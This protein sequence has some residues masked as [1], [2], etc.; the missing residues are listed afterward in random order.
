MFAA[1][2]HSN[3]RSK[4]VVPS[5]YLD[6]PIALVDVLANKGRLD[7]ERLMVAAVL[8][9][10][11]E[12]THVGGMVHDLAS[13]AQFHESARYAALTVMPLNPR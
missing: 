8:H 7:D 10:T 11:L 9:D 2:K 4:D 12:D 13:Q 3:Q 1:Y 5:P 6:N